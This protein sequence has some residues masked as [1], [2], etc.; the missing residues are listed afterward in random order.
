MSGRGC[1]G[2][3]AGTDVG[4]RSSPRRESSALLSRLAEQGSERNG[5]FRLLQDPP[6]FALGL[7]NAGDF[8]SG[9][10]LHY[11]VGF[12]RYLCTW[13]GI[14]SARRYPTGTICSGV[15]T[16]KLEVHDSVHT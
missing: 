8:V 11:E 12:L 2:F 7:A 14:D 6:F 1:P 4:T 13:A 10:D 16:C 5:G 3:S 9:L 15:Q